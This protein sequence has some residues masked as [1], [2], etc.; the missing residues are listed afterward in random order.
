MV[1]LNKIKN[2][3]GFTFFE[4]ILSLNIMILFCVVIVPSMTVLLQNKESLQLINVADDIL[5]DSIHTYYLNRVDF[6][7]GDRFLN[8]QLFTIYQNDMMKE[9]TQ[10]CVKWIYRTKESEICEKI[11]K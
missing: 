5:T 3:R 2:E 10:I 1:D 6:S 9:Y 11:T 8:G 7:E 4:S